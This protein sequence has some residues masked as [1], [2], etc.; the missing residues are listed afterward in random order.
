MDQLIAQLQRLEPVFNFIGFLAILFG[1]WR[2]SK[3]FSDHIRIAE[4]NRNEVYITEC[5]RIIEE[6]NQMIWSTYYNI[7]ITYNG[8]LSNA[9]QKHLQLSGSKASLFIT[10]AHNLDFFDFNQANHLLSQFNVNA[11]LAFENKPPDEFKE[12]VNKYRSRFDCYKFI[13][14]NQKKIKENLLDDSQNGTYLS[15]SKIIQSIPANSKEFEVEINHIIY[16]VRKSLNSKL[17][18]YL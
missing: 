13:Y 18:S 9:L 16:P 11:N 14:K 1:V 12:M 4:Y 8:N 5:L 15:A 7:Q 2:A 10:L 3:Y 17:R 6:L